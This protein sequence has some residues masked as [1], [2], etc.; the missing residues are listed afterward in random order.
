MILAVVLVVSVK[1]TPLVFTPSFGSSFKYYS[2]K[3]IPNVLTSPTQT[4][5]I[6]IRIYIDHNL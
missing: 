2:K 4:C 6:N 3:L 1:L 5:V